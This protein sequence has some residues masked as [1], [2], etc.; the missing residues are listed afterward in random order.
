MKTQKTKM[1][2]K[3]LYHHFN[4]RKDFF[5]FEC[6]IGWYGKEIVDCIMY[7]CD[8][9]IICYEIKQS[10][11]DFYSKNKLTF[12]GNKNYFVMPYELYQQ[13][14]S[15]IPPEI[16]CYVSIKKFDRSLL[17][18]NP[19]INKVSDLYENGFDELV[20]I[21]SASRLELKA[22]KEVILSSMLRSMQRD[23]IFNLESIG[24]E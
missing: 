19:N 7:N 16:G 5:V 14:K 8:R 1:L 12:I 15:D 21:K 18:N 6:T 2:E 11:Q 3:L 4:D 10:K 22:D 23:R 13:V 24:S 20:N 9:E 17:Y